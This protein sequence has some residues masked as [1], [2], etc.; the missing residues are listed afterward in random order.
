MISVSQLAMGNRIGSVCVEKIGLIRRGAA[1]MYTEYLT[2]KPPL[3][4]LAESFNSW[5]GSRTD[6]QLDAFFDELPLAASRYSLL[7]D[8]LA[9][10]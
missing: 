9:R 7:V 6:L 1:R 3:S 2:E 8:S 5:G 4:V 10:E